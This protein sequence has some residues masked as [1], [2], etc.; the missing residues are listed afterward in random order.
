MSLLNIVGIIATL[1]LLIFKINYLI[2]QTQDKD[3]KN[4]I[5]IFET[6]WGW[7][8]G[9]A[10]GI[11]TTFMMYVYNIPG[12]YVQIVDLILT[13][14]IISI[15]DIKWNLIPNYLV[16][17]LLLSQIIASFCITKAYLNLWNVLIS[18]LIL[19]ILMFV[20]KISK[21]QIGMGDVKLITGINLIYGLAFTAYSLIFSMLLMLL[22]SIP[23]LVLKKIKLKSQM[24]FAPFYLLGVAIY[25][26]LNLI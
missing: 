19:I 16:I 13:L 17:T 5:K 4:P 15:I 10:F 24:P 14:I 9:F 1:I 22:Y 25:T 12:Y 23:L 6:I 3:T 21:E 18:A 11:I 2:R 26:I 7:P 8:I 20:S